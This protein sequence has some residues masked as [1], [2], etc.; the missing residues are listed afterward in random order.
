MCEK[1]VN[2]VEEP[3]KQEDQRVETV[4]LAPAESAIDDDTIEVK[5]LDLLSEEIKLLLLQL[6]KKSLPINLHNVYFS[7]RLVHGNL[8]FTLLFPYSINDHSG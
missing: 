5:G 6:L 8:E 4:P 1:R 7:T 3:E 2:Q